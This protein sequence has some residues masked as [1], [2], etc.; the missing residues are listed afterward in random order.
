[1]HRRFTRCGKEWNGFGGG[2]T[3]TPPK[4]KSASKLLATDGKNNSI[5]YQYL[6]T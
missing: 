1:M 5:T 3:R 2:S 6:Y 4:N